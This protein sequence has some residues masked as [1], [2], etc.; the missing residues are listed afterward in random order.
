[1][2]T[3]KYFGVGLTYNRECRDAKEHE[4]GH[5]IQCKVQASWLQG[6]EGIYGFGVKGLGTVHRS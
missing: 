2:E 1:M 5:T 4:P 3:C 6:N